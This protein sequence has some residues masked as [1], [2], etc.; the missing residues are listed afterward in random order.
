MRLQQRKDHL[1]NKMG[2][3][4]CSGN[5]TTAHT[6]MKH[7]FLFKAHWQWGPLS[8]GRDLYS[9]EFMIQP[10][11]LP[12]SNRY[13]SEGLF[14]P[15]YCAWMILTQVRCWLAKGWAWASSPFIAP[16]WDFVVSLQTQN[17][18]GLNIIKSHAAGQNIITRRERGEI[19][20]LLW[21]ALINTKWA[22]DISDKQLWAITGEGLCVQRSL[23]LIPWRLISGG[24][25][26]GFREIKELWALGG[27][28]IQ[29]WRR[30]LQQS[31][32]KR[33]KGGAQA[34]CGEGRCC[35]HQ[36]LSHSQAA[37]PCGM[38]LP[39]HT[40]CLDTWETRGMNL[41]SDLGLVVLYQPF[42]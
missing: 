27:F 2:H 41:S 36:L 39:A 12:S 15:P 17:K 19:V 11:F 4:L 10:A 9:P 13:K 33:R 5:K 25:G 20:F 1:R 16:I 3:L 40:S 37:T 30:T 29:N 32:A 38:L 8:F 14:S 18:I 34:V 6:H 31:G 28:W 35:L 7:S 24:L 21:I 26:G 23:L 22:D 42:L